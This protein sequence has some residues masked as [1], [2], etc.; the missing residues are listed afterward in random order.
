MAD[1]LDFYSR[2]KDFMTEKG[3]FAR[4]FVDFFNW[5]SFL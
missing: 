5:F 3:W 1:Y 2:N 4:F